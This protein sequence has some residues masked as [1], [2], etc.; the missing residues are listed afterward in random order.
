MIRSTRA[1]VI[2]W[3][4]QNRRFVTLFVLTSI[5]FIVAIVL[6]ALNDAK[7]HERLI[8]MGELSDDSCA[9][10]LVDPDNGTSEELTVPPI[11][12]AP[13]CYHLV[14]QKKRQTYLLVRSNPAGGG[15]E[16]IIYELLPNGEL[17]E[18]QTFSLGDIQITS[19]IQWIGDDN[20]YF[21]GITATEHEQIY[22]LDRQ[23]AVISPYIQYEDRFI[24]Y[25]QLSPSGKFLLYLVPN[26]AVKDL[27]SCPND[28][29]TWW[30]FYL[31][32]VE[33][34]RGVPLNSLAQPPLSESELPHC[35]VYWS[36]TGRWAAV[37]VECRR[38]E[39]PDYTAIVDVEAFAVVELISKRAVKWVSPTTLVVEEWPKNRSRTNRFTDYFF[40][41]AEFGTTEPMFETFPALDDIVRTTLD[42]WSQ[43][44]QITSGRSEDEEGSIVF[45]LPMRDPHELSAM[46]H[47]KESVYPS[48]LSPSGRWAAFSKAVHEITNGDE[49]V[50]IA[51]TD[52]AIMVEID[53]TLKYP[54]LT[55]VQ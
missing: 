17:Q 51:N 25:P 7:N 5:L 39:G 20:I 48:H 35:G 28:R 4:L 29:C 16:L 49:R 52:G 36:P 14:V 44:G 18:E 41:S 8:V 33:Q 26:S 46:A 24:T 34:Q 21:S 1:K 50:Y 53:V 38:P 23:T 32:D 19:P 2:S 27:N 11:A 10:W 54:R 40:Y 9:L 13:E 42:D 47:F 43:D 12:S 45:T 31:W 55:W 22:H 30:Q 3:R 37:L 15:E 6:Y